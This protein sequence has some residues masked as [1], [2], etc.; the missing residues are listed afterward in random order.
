MQF[1]G[2]AGVVAAFHCSGAEQLFN[3]AFRFGGHSSYQLDG[4]AAGFP[5]ANIFRAIFLEL[6]QAF[7]ES[8]ADGLGVEVKGVANL[9]IAQIA[10]IA[11]FDDFAARLAELVEGLVHQGGLFGTHEREV[12]RRGVAGRVEGQA[13]LGVFG[14]ERNGGLAAAAFGRVLALA[15]IVRLVRGDAEQ[16]GLKLAPAME[17]IEVADDGQEDFLAN[18]LDVLAWKSC[19]S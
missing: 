14:L 1:E 19:P 16:P 9:V 18:L 12:R 11:Q 17:G 3:W 7:A 2:C 13:G 15:I 10:E 8:R 4:K 5:R 6:V